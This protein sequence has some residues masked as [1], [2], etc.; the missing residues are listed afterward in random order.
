MP[1][2]RLAMALLLAASALPLASCATTAPRAAAITPSGPLAVGAHE[3]TI[4]GVRIWYRVAG[5]WDGR[6]APVVF[7]AG[8][9]GGNSYVF[10]R[11][12]G[13][14]LEPN[15]LMVYYHQ[16][17]TGR[18]ERPASGDYALATLAADVEALRVHLGVP[19][20]AIVAHSFGAVIGLEFAARFPDRLAAAILAGG[21]WNA[22]L[23]CREQAGRIEANHPDA[24]RSMIAA[25]PLTDDGVCERVFGAFRGAARERFNEENMFPGR[26]ALDELNRLEAE[27][28][29]SNTRELSGAVFRQG[30]LQYRFA[31][32]PRVTAPVLV[33]SGALDYAAGPRTQR[34]LAEALPRGRLIEYPGL[35]HWMF[36]EDPRRFA[37]DASAFLRSAPRN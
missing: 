22:P 16:R 15:R 25:G 9:P 13:P 28:G 5:T 14:H 27:S 18:S 7:L 37:R 26:A 32:A 10:E 36:I 2:P 29:L 35:G 19:K 31:G 11:T 33:L 8:G 1:R 21:L 6:S 17:G 23:S 34:A 12:A 24:Y 4:A 30:L 3:A 20:I